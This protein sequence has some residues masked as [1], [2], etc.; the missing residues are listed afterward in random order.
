MIYVCKQDIPIHS[1]TSHPSTWCMLVNR[2]SQF[3]RINHVDG[4]GDLFTNINHVDGWDVL[5]WMGMSC[6]QA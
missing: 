2:T 4:W 5:F 6:L 3:I 1:R